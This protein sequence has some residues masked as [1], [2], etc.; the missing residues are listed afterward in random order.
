MRGGRDG[1]AGAA[2]KGVQNA[3][4]PRASASGA[5]ASGWTLDRCVGGCIE[6]VVLVLDDLEVRRRLSSGIR[7]VFGTF[8]ALANWR[9]PSRWIR[10]RIRACRVW[11]VMQE[12]DS[13]G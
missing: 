8:E 10:V 9:V 5:F 3:S 6:G 4:E 12:G 13:V 11:L 7:G 2:V 1:G